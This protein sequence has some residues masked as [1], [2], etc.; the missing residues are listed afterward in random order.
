[1]S[2]HEKVTEMMIKVA[3][4]ESLL[5]VA[6]RLCD[7]SSLP[8]CRDIL[9]ETGK[10][11]QSMKPLLETVDRIGNAL[12]QQADALIEQFLNGTSA[13]YRPYSATQIR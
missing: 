5:T 6:H 8:A 9:N 11:I 12:R 1:M 3:T 13:Q 7:R 10:V 2:H 4:A